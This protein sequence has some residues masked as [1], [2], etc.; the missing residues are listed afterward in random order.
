[1]FN[2]YSNS[3]LL[4]DEVELGEDELLDAL[5][6][7]AALPRRRRAAAAVTPLGRRGGGREAGE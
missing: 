5:V 7:V 4:L 6:A 3:S 2:F 1:M